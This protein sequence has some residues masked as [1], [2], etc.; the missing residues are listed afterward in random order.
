MLLSK[1]VPPLPHVHK[2]ILCMYVSVAALQIDSS[3]PSF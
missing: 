1:F 3:M 2:S